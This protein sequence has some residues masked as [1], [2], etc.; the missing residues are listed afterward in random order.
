MKEILEKYYHIDS[1][2]AEADRCKP[3]LWALWAS[4]EQFSQGLR[5]NTLPILRVGLGVL[6]D[7]ELRWMLCMLQGHK[8]NLANATVV[9]V[10]LLAIRAHPQGKVLAAVQSGP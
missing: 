4:Q 7:L 2:E 3:G 8:G 6:L 9:V 10:D 1:A 5:G